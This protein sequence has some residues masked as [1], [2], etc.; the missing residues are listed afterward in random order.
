MLQE[1]KNPSV[2]DIEVAIMPASLVQLSNRLLEL[3]TSAQKYVC[4]AKRKNVEREVIQTTRKTKEIVESLLAIAQK[5]RREFEI[6]FE[7]NADR[8]FRSLFAGYGLDTCKE[9]IGE[10][11]KQA[12]LNEE[13][14][15]N[16]RKQTKTDFEKSNQIYQTH[17]KRLQELGRKL[18]AFLRRKAIR[19]AGGWSV[20]ANYDAC[21]SEV[22]FLIAQEV[23]VAAKYVCDKLSYQHESFEA[24]Q[25]K[26]T[27]A[28]TPVEVTRTGSLLL[29]TVLPRPEDGQAILK[30]LFNVEKLETLVRTIIQKANVG[31]F[32]K[33]IDEEIDCAL[34]NTSIPESVIAYLNML[35]A[36]RKI[37]NNCSMASLPWVP[38]NDKMAP[39]KNRARLK[40]ISIPGGATENLYNELRSLNH[41]SG[42]A[43]PI[44]IDDETR[45]TVAAEERYLALPEIKEWEIAQLETCDVPED[46]FLAS[47]TVFADESVVRNYRPNPYDA[48]KAERILILALAMGLIVRDGDNTYRTVNSTI[49]ASLPGL[50]DDRIEKGYETMVLRLRVDH[51]LTSTLGTLVDE[52]LEKMGTRQTCEALNIMLDDTNIVPKAHI[53]QAHEILIEELTSRGCAITSDIKNRSS[54]T[55]IES[56]TAVA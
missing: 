21:I 20:N 28:A 52:Q 36:K 22:K 3:T 15:N 50:H 54:I 23:S 1:W 42:Q 19:R 29:D 41:T 48:R 47:V 45:I 13:L 10:Y 9:H 33:V 25:D 17:F 14:L 4:K 35:P 24:I 26:I 39:G 44:D 55:P 16:K 5:N 12:S 32:E 34:L 8:A 30:N 2:E 7:S 46:R 37:L 49:A 53:R 11:H 38:I 31:N 6:R 18:L 43:R 27:M 56:V 40:L 51:A